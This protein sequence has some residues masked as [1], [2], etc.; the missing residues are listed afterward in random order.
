LKN[1]N[2]DAYWRHF[3]IK[4]GFSPSNEFKDLI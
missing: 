4:Y 1:G 3:A 2:Y